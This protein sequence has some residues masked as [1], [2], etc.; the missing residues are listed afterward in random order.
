[1]KTDRIVRRLWSVVLVAGMGLAPLSVSAESLTDAM[2]GAYRHSG[3]LEQNR[4]TLRAAD[5]DVAQAMATLRPVI[6][7]VGTF[8]YNNSFSSGRDSS[9]TTLALTMEQLLYDFGTSRLGI[10][11]AK[12]SVLATREAL[13]GIEQ[14]VLLA[15]ITAFLNVR[16]DSAQVNLRNSNLRLIDRELSAARDRFEV[17][18]VTRTDV[19]IAESRLAAAR[20]GLA[21]AK[22]NLERSNEAYRNAVGRYPGTLSQPPLPPQSAK[23]LDDARAVGRRTHPNIRRSMRLVTVQEL[24]IERAMAGM[25]PRITAEGRVGVNENFDNASSIGI[26]IGGPIYQGGRLSSGVRKAQ[27]GRDGA[28]AG[29]HTTQHLVEQNI[30]NAWAQLAVSRASLSASDEQ[31]RA[32]TVAF[33]GVQEEATLGA[34]TTLDVLN[35]EQELLNAR[36]ARITSDTDQVTSVYTLLAA[37]GLLTVEHL[38]L[39]IVTYDPNAYYN[40]VRD[41]PTRFVSPQGEKL[42][43]IMKSLGKK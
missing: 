36:A 28:R 31:V 35:A 25:M 14:D 43:R 37:M 20:S 8:T 17:G 19:A 38:G 6:N 2:I 30:G 11:I 33:R 13:I 41:A 15:A 7:Y 12:E 34:R 29:L 5:E 21:L 42:D 40:A 10:D 27:A 26:R 24:A 18:E 22:G 9:D 32:S 23:T 39:D 3:L 4:A 16:R 1:M